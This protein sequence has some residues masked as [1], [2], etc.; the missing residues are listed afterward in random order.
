MGFFD[1]LIGGIASVFGANKAADE[2]AASRRQQADFAKHGIQYKVA[3]AKA[4]GI[5]PYAALGASTSMPAAVTGDTSGY[6]TAGQNIGRALDALS[7]QE[8]RN[9]ELDTK[10]K[11][12]QLD[13]QNLI[14]AGLASELVTRSSGVPPARPTLD[15]S[16]LVDGQGAA[17]R[18]RVTVPVGDKLIKS[19]PQKLTPSDPTLAGVAPGTVND[20]AFSTDPQGN[21]YPIPSKEVMEAQSN[22]MLGMLSWNI[23]NRIMPALGYGKQYVPDSRDGKKYRFNPWLSRYEPN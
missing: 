22:D 10:I 3:D 14:N 21:L 12:S 17:K 23:R 1:G 13:N 16:Y 20:Y 2:A 6:A 15:Q 8:T 5:N 9:A 11:Q 4:S 7:P 19:E 18:L